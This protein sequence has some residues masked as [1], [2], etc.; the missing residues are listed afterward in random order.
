MGLYKDI[1]MN[2]ISKYTSDND[3]NTKNNLLDLLKNR[4]SSQNQLNYD[5][6]KIKIKNISSD[7]SSMQNLKVP[8]N[9]SELNKTPKKLV[10][11]DKYSILEEINKSMGSK[12]KK[13]KT[14]LFDTPD[15][16]DQKRTD[17]K[18]YTD[19]HEKKINN[20]HNVRDLNFKINFEDT[21]LLKI[22]EPSVNENIISN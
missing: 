8:I 1:Q 2:L 4:S 5:T 20:K 7:K 9:K 6:N 14:Q 3:K 15:I 12:N 10:K 16:N 11:K 21:D 18:F 19:I 17:E 22:N 13:N